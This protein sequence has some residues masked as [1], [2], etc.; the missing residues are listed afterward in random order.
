VARKRS[1]LVCGL[2]PEQLSVV[3]ALYAAQPWTA[4][5]LP[6]TSEL[7]AILRGCHSVGLTFNHRDLSRLLISL[8]KHDPSPLPL[9]GRSPGRMSPFDRQQEAILV[10]LY[11]AQSLA[12]DQLPY[13][14][15]FEKLVKDFRA[16]TG[17][18]WHPMV[19][20]HRLLNIRRQP[21]KG[22]PRKTDR[23]PRNLPPDQPRLFG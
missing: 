8:R 4:D 15:E 22:L 7:N 11:D 14:P 12:S 20:F 17:R 21:S 2:T 6:Y 5:R 10:E 9:K 19:V 16:L 18:K 3:V 13:T 23:K 1:D